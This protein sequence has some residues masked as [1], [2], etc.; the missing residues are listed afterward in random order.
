MSQ[1]NHQGPAVGFVASITGNVGG[2]CVNRNLD[3]ESYSLQ[4]GDP[5]YAQDVLRSGPDSTLVVQFQDGSKWTL[6]PLAQAEIDPALL[7]TETRLAAQPAAQDDM[8]GLFDQEVD[9]NA[10]APTAAGGAVAN[11]DG[12]GVVILAR[13]TESDPYQAFE[14]PGFDTEGDQRVLDLGDVVVP[15]DT[16]V[17]ADSGGSTDPAPFRVFEEGGSFGG[18]FAKTG[19]GSSSG[20]SQIIS[21]AV[22]GGSGDP[23][24]DPTVTNT[25]P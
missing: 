2:L 5:V 18:L 10:L 3:V 17:I 8:Q 20:G 24:F 19:G 11:D 22:G 13:G 14:T 16:I 1:P 15:E 25:I 21:L 9:L 12:T 4:V 6:G 23:V 7:G